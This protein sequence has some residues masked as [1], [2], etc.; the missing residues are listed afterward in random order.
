MLIDTDVLIWSFRGRESAR[1]AIAESD[2]T[3]LSIISYMELV[4][5]VH[6]K[7]ELQRLRAS[8]RTNGWQVI[9]LN[10]DVGVRAAAYLETYGLSDGLGL[11]D[12]LI[13][14]TAVLRGDALMTANVRHYRCIR[15]LALVQ[16]VPD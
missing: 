2:S 1:K 5:G 4:Q 14:A 8:I 3:A 10:E 7:K 13:A 16:Y 9:G 12:S 15:E 11:A 6:D